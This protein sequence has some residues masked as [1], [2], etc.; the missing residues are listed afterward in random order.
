MNEIRD[1][2]IEKIKEIKEINLNLLQKNE[3]EEE[4]ESDLE[5]LIHF[6]CVLLE[7]PQSWSLNGL[8]LW[9]NYW[10][11]NQNDLEFLRKTMMN[12]FIRGPW[13]TKLTLV[14]PF[15]C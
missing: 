11:L 6:D 8:L 3:E 9:I 13:T 10:F 4:L 14:H 1:E 15:I 12:E 2:Q 7:R 5:K